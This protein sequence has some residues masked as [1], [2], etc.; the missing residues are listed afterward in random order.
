VNKI[1]SHNAKSMSDVLCSVQECRAKPLGDPQRIIVVL[2]PPGAGL[3]A[4]YC[5][6]LRH[7]GAMLVPA[8]PMDPN[9]VR[10]IKLLA[11]RTRIVPVLLASAEDWRS[12]RRRQP[13]AAAQIR[14]RTFMTAELKAPSFVNN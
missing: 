7:H 13:I 5:Q 11:N 12:W 10:F 4:S 1:R 3:P 9:R 6:A 2:M 8:G 14:R